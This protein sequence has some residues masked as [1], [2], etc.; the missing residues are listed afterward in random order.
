M[1]AE[2]RSALQ[3]LEINKGEGGITLNAVADINA[4]VTASGGAKVLDGISGIE[5]GEQQRQEM[6]LYERAG[7]SQGSFRLR[8]EI[9][10]PFATEVLYSEVHGVLRDVSPGKDGICLEGTLYISALV[11]SRTGAMSQLS[12]AIPFTQTV[13][14]EA[15][16]PMW[17]EVRAVSYTHLTLPTT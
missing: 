17:G 11:Q 7:E 12:Q 5:D 10:A 9:E 14:G 15:L 6:T 3:S 16:T 8:E 4:M 13:D 2:V 1:R